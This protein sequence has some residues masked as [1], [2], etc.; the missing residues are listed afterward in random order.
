MA[1]I[2]TAENVRFSSSARPRVIRNNPNSRWL[3]TDALR[4][5]FADRLRQYERE[6]KKGG[7]FSKSNWGIFAPAI[8]IYRA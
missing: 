5:F 3:M 2:V 4:R 6:L 8:L 1:F 7:S